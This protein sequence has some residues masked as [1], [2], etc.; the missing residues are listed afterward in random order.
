MEL[1][2]PSDYARSLRSRFVGGRQFRPAV[3]ASPAAAAAPASVRQLAGDRLPFGFDRRRAGPDRRLVGPVVRIETLQPLGE[4][5]AILRRAGAADNPLHQLAVLPSQPCGL[6]GAQPPTQHGLVFDDGRLHGGL[7]ASGGFGPRRSKRTSRLGPDDAGLV[8]QCVPVEGE[9]RMRVL[10]RLLDFGLE[11]PPTDFQTG[12]GSEQIEHA[13]LPAIGMQHDGAFVAAPVTGVAEE[14][15][16]FLRS[17]FA[18]FRF[19]APPDALFLPDLAALAG[20]RRAAAARP[21]GFFSGRAAAVA[22]DES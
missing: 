18:G 1:A 8:E 14:R 5:V 20:G 13:R 2:F 17:P 19:F 6:A 22:A 10:E 12:R 9:V 3:V 15:A 21:P 4:P 16:H 7:P 11:R